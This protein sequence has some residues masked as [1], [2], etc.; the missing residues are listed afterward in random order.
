MFNAGLKKRKEKKKQAA[1]AFLRRKKSERES[2]VKKN[3]KQKTRLFARVCS[4]REDLF[5]GIADVKYLN[6]N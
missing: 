6:E 1:F 4:L 2:G 5:R 3:K